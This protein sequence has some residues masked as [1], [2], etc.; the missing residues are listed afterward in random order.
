MESNWRYNVAWIGLANSSTRLAACFVDPPQLGAY[1]LMAAG[2]GGAWQVLWVSLDWE[3]FPI[4]T[5]VGSR[6]PYGW[7]VQP[8]HP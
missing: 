2:T 8:D 3:F 1:W 7:D 5:G 4:F 6:F